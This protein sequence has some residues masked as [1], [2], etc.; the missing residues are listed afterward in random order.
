MDSSYSLN[1]VI[2]DCTT[3]E[4]DAFGNPFG[5]N[6]LMKDPPKVS[7]EDTLVTPTLE[8]AETIEE[9]RKCIRRLVL[10]KEELSRIFD[11]NSKRVRKKDKEIRRLKAIIAEIRDLTEDSDEDSS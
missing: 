1:G 10:S 7:L 4:N 5:G 11:K 3:Q 6:F 8:F 9:W 2:S